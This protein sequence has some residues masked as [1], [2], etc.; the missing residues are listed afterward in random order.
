VKCR[1][2]RQPIRR[3]RPGDGIDPRDY[4]W[5]HHDGNPLCDMSPP[6][7]EP[8]AR[9]EISARTSCERCGGRMEYSG[10]HRLGGSMF[11]CQSC[12]T[13]ITP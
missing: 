12:G 5:V 1:N 10:E 11:T 6:Y 13:T 8:E 4:Q 9:D 3:V 2:C 7:A